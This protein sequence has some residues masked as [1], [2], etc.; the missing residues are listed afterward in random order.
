MSAATMPGGFWA[1][2]WKSLKPRAVEEPIDVWVHRPLAY[3]LAKALLPTPVSPNLVTCVSIVLGLGSGACFVTAFPGHL[4]V[5]GLLL[6]ASA[7]V[8]CADGQLARLRGTSSK[9]GRMLDGVAD[10][11]VSTA[12]VAGAIWVLVTSHLDPPWL[13][14]LTLAVAVATAVTGSFHTTMYD[15][16]KNVHLRMTT[17]GFKEGEAYDAARARFDA[18]RAGGLSLVKWFVWGIY[19]F[20]VKSQEDFVRKFDPHTASSLSQLPPYS[21]RAAATYARNTEHVMRV[22]RN[23]FGF[24]SLVFGIAAATFLD[25]LE[26]YMVLRLVGMNAVFYGWLRPAQRAA[27]ERAFR[28]IA[29]L[30][31]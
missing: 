5:A 6:F 14:A 31:A 16:Y 15:H 19:L 11:V 25:L 2:Y 7:I 13:G 12:T 18:E 8:D 3:V 29:A 10:L 23:W 26:V 21:E 9:F 17:P 22:W 24:G 28:E 1:G 27:S 30:G 20:Y 4:R